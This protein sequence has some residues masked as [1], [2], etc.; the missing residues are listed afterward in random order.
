MALPD[1]SD[2]SQTGSLP[3]SRF[4]LSRMAFR[5]KASVGP[6]ITAHARPES[7]ARVMEGKASDLGSKD[8]EMSPNEIIQCQVCPS[9]IYTGLAA[10]ISFWDRYG[11]RSSRPR[12]QIPF[13]LRVPFAESR[14]IHLCPI[15]R[16]AFL[17]RENFQQ[18]IL[19]KVVVERSVSY[20]TGPYNNSHLASVCN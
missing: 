11:S 8:M 5:S 16:G 19:P 7:L 1:I 13:S 14:I 18:Y 4:N 10:D 15:T 9:D 12:A 20:Q 2:P 17:E 6:V 3:P